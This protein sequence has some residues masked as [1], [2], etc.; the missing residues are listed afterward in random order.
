MC[1]CHHFISTINLINTWRHPYPQNVLNPIHASQQINIFFTLSV[2]VERQTENANVHKHNFI[3]TP[4][5]N[6]AFYFKKKIYFEWHKKARLV[7]TFL[8]TSP[9]TLLHLFTRD[10]MH[11][12]PATWLTD[13]AGKWEIS[14]NIEENRKCVLFS[15]WKTCL[16]CL[17]S[18]L[19]L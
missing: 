13:W 12:T 11:C 4:S 18:C 5:L 14:N 15:I 16:T 6:T 19:L 17:L 10:F 2:C 1:K 8:P 7:H 9:A 3:F